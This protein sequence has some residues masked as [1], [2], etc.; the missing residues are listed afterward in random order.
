MADKVHISFYNA[1]QVQNLR[2]NLQR[3]SPR[4]LPGSPNILIGGHP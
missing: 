3:P 2:V 1:D 4:R